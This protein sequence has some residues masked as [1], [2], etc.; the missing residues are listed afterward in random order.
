MIAML[1][2]VFEIKSIVNHFVL[3]PRLQAELSIM[4][5][6]YFRFHDAKASFIMVAPDVILKLSVTFP[7]I[8]HTIF[9]AMNKHSSIQI[10]HHNFH[11]KFL[12][13]PGPDKI[14]AG[15]NII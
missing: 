11:K 8:I 5:T 4:K 7:T 10:N 14:M 2:F 12:W 13:R 3:H 9:G 1:V 15:S 6:I